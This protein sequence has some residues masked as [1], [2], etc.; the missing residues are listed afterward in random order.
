MGYFMNKNL[1]QKYK[2]LF[3]WI[4]SVIVVALLLGI[5]YK[6]C[7]VYFETIDDRAINDIFAGVL[8]GKPDGHAIFVNYLLGA[9][10]AAL[11]SV[12]IHVAWY[13]LFLIA[14]H[15]VVYVCF[16]G[17]LLEQ[18]ETLVQHICVLISTCFLVA[19]NMYIFGEIQY[20]STASILAAIGYFC[21]LF[22]KKSPKRK[23]IL[24]FVFE[25][26]ALLLRSQ[27]MLMIQ[28]V[29]ISVVGV[30]MLVSLYK[31]ETD[32]KTFAKRIGYIGGILCACL[33]VNVIGNYVIG[34]YADKEW[35]DYTHYR[36]LRG[37]MGDYYGFPAYE[38]VAH[39]L[40]A[41]KDGY[42]RNEYLAFT[43]YWIL[44]NEI[45]IDA[46]EQIHAIAKEKYEAS[47]GSIL[48]ILQWLKNSRNEQGIMGYGDYS[49][50]LY[51]V[52]LLLAVLLNKWDVFLPVLGLNLG[53]NIA[54]GYLSYRGRIPFRASSGL[55]FV[56]LLL[57]VTCLYYLIKHCREK[58]IVY[59]L[60]VC[61]L[62][63]CVA[64][65]SFTPMRDTYRYLIS[66][67]TSKEI[68]SKG[69]DDIIAYCDKENEGFVAVELATAYYMGEA[70]ETDWNKNRNYLSSG[71]WWATSPNVDAYQKQYLQKHKDNL[72]LI[73]MG[74][75]MD[76]WESYAKEL[77]ETD[78][79]LQLKAVE[80]LQ[81]QNGIVL[82]VYQING[83][84]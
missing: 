20:T 10:M 15:F 7:G 57:L 1:F 49:K 9:A 17:I 60:L 77:F 13:G 44:Q 3:A 47:R 81:L 67:H 62:V 46:L 29:G 78:W 16:T 58:H 26:L 12:N 75:G 24:F 51:L 64:K 39:I 80:Q 84:K 32:V 63:L 28:I 74:E 11:Y 54:M 31:K 34:D 53:R 35:R 8:T 27:A 14:C 2:K 21:L 19:T 73:E 23:Y 5:L 83:I 33:F 25:L 61:A 52:V 76:P 56:E 30:S 38:E 6:I 55:Y 18:S 82:D 71:L 41:T 36:E 79:G 22:D 42:S 68:M 66:Q 59:K 48:D 37:D 4:E 65:A 40:D 43:R 45:D 50:I 72:Y 69:M 70:L